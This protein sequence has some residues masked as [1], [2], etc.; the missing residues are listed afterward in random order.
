MNIKEIVSVIKPNKII[1]N[2]ELFIDNFSTDT[3]TIKEN[4]AYIGLKGDT[5]DGSDFWK[6]AID[7]GSHLLILSKY[8]KDLLDYS[9]EKFISILIVEDTL[10]SLGKLASYKRDK[11]NIP[12]IAITGSAGKTSTKDMVYSVLK[13]KYNVQKT[14]GNYNNQIG[15]PLT[16]L[17]LKD[18]QILVLEM[19]M[20]HLGEISYLSKIAKPNIA[21]ITNIGTAHIGNLGNRENILKAKL[22]ILDGMSLSGKIIINN[23]NDLLHEWYLKNNDNYKIITV[24]I[25]NKSNFMPKNII[26]KD[27]SS[28]YIYNDTK[29]NIPVGGRHFI[30]NSLFALA[31]G[32]I[33]NMLPLQ[34][35]KGLKDFKLSG[36][37]MRI[38]KNNGISIIDDSYNANYDAV[39]SALKYLSEQKGRLIACLGTMRELG[40]YSKELHSKLGHDIVNDKINYLITVGEDSNYI[41][42]TAI[43][44]GF[45]PQKS[46]HYN[47]NDDA[48]NKIN[49]IKKDGDFILV[50]ASYL[51]HFNEIVEKIIQ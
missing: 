19:G 24:G 15:L 8:N 18:E 36:N 9:K 45:D 10:T 31:V 21:I 48:I 47:N 6:N 34:I 13:E 27:I 37:R 30:Y 29:I 14:Q 5:Y 46:F 16:I 17:G 4:D 39:S 35:S 1:N 41:N 40:K 33:Y 28:S 49:E 51:L 50:K 25:N 23:D 7:K 26:E 38:I 11:L 32:S 2:Q 44:L 20:N 42:E 12:I 3:R 43:K 22:E